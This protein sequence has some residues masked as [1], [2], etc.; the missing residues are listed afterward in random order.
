MSYRSTV[1]RP[2]AS[3]AARLATAPPELVTLDVAALKSGV[4]GVT[5]I[6]ASFAAATVI[7]GELVRR[8][9]RAFPVRC[10]NL[11]GGQLTDGIIAL[12]HRGRSV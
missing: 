11:S 4:I 6:G 10:A 7:A 5:G 9:R 1:A 8:G 2:P 3:L 12:S